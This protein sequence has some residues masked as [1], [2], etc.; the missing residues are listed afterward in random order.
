MTSTPPAVGVVGEANQQQISETDDEQEGHN[1]I[2]TDH[3]S[4]YQ[5]HEGQ[6]NAGDNSMGE[7]SCQSEVDNIDHLTPSYA[8]RTPA[9]PDSIE[10]EQMSCFATNDVG[11][12]L[13]VIREQQ[14][15]LEQIRAEEESMKL[16]RFLAQ[17]MAS[18]DVRQKVGNHGVGGEPMNKTDATE[19]LLCDFLV[20]NDEEAE[21]M[22]NT[23]QYQ[24]FIRLSIHQ[25]QEAEKADFK[26]AAQVADID[27]RE[28]KKNQMDPLKHGDKPE[29]FSSRKQLEKQGAI[30]LVND[31][32]NAGK[33]ANKPMVV[34]EGSASMVVEPR[35]EQQRI[36]SSTARLGYHIS[37][38]IITRDGKNIRMTIFSE[39][40]P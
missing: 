10:E 34:E 31:A 17:Q 21:C 24:E 9:V 14:Q 7:T 6:G 12:S 4:W 1:G 38:R 29:V 30:L 18:E 8:A 35:A 5:G 33:R 22:M 36:S 3:L 25:Q 13:D 32:D 23:I 26:L 27:F 40:I 20:D 37:E 16:S 39:E 19:G 28:G 11:L 2:V 15:I